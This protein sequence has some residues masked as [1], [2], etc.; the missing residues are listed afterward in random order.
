LRRVFPRYD[1]E[2]PS[3]SIKK[4]E[5]GVRPLRVE[6]HGQGVG[7]R[8]VEG[9]RSEGGRVEGVVVGVVVVGDGMGEGSGLGCGG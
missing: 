6:K 9:W 7:G 4:V 1:G 8:E 2:P 5:R 3:L